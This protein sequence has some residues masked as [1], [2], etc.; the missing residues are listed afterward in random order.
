ME[1]RAPGRN[2]GLLQGVALLWLG[3]LVGFAVG[4]E[5]IRS[6]PEPPTPSG[7]IDLVGA[8]ATLPYPLYR[9][10]FADYGRAT[11]VRINYFSVGSHEGIRLLLAD[12]VDFGAADRPFTRDERARARCGPIEL[13]TVVG[14]VAVAYRLP[15]LAQPLR[16]DAD[17][18][19]DIFTGRIQR[20]DDAALRALNPGVALPALPIVVVRRARSTGTSALFARYLASSARWRA[21]SALTAASAQV[22][23]N[24]GVTA[25]IGA[26][27][28]AI[29][30]VE[31]TYAKQAGLDVAALRNASGAFVAP[32]PAAIG[33]AAEELLT[34]A[35]IDTALGA[36]GAAAAAAYPAVALTRI[37]ADAALGDERRAAHFLAFARWALSDGAAV[38]AELGYAPLPARIAD[39]Q[40]RRLDLLRPGR[41]PATRA[42]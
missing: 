21:D 35:S 28:G 11:G 16:L 3:L 25:A 37:S 7:S 4:I 22:E 36:V 15:G 32:S 5:Y 18:L 24:E 41:C 2:V 40:R 29:G 9:R 8:G 38:A 19:V 27:T 33:A 23:G 10:W 14:A 42:P 1:R 34:P 13:P 6:R 30:V 31:F 26:Q 12:S 39:D 17:L 20:W